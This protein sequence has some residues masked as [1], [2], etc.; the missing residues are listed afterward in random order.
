MIACDSESQDPNAVA[1]DQID[2]GGDPTD[3]TGTPTVSCQVDA[4]L[5]TLTTAGELQW[6]DA[7][8]MVEVVRSKAEGCLQGLNIELGEEAGCRLKLSMAVSDTQLMIESGTLTIVDACASDLSIAEGI[9]VADSETSTAG[10]VQDITG[11]YSDDA[12]CV[13][14]DTL[15]LMGR[16][17]F[18]KAASQTEVLAVYLDTMPISGSVVDALAEG[19][20]CA[21]PAV[22]CAGMNCGEDAYGMACGE[23]SGELVCNDNSCGEALCPPSGPY[24]TDPGT[25]ATDVTLTDCDGNTKSIH[26]MCGANAAHIN[27]LAGW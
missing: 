11:A 10:I 12:G 25:I 20:S 14:L 22:S 5:S 1:G 19:A 9:Y 2:N 15:S 3:D 21:D 18:R 4:I 27:L 17:S 23:C 7:E 13:A 8:P 26:E 16:V 24:G 6:P